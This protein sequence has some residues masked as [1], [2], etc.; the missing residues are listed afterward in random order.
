MKRH[1]MLILPF[2]IFFILSLNSAAVAERGESVE[3]RRLFTTYC[4]LCHGLTGRGD[5]PLAGKIRVP[6]RDLVGSG[7]VKQ[8]SDAELYAIIDG[9]QFHDLVAPQMPRW[10]DVLTDRQ[11]RALVS[12]VRFLSLSPNP[13]IGDPDAGEVSYRQY[14]SPCHGRMGTGDGVMRKILPIKP[15][16]HSNA[17]KM[18]EITNEQMIDIITNG[19]GKNSLMPAWK[20]ILNETE[21]EDLV[22]YIRLLSH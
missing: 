9:T 2:F 15:A 8:R 18:D 17:A 10:G 7:I 16:D 5:G 6:P 12:Y 1:P 13:L 20:G 14:C 22:G 3:G 4:Y 21:I 19:K 11:I